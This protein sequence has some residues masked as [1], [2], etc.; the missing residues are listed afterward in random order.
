MPSKNKRTGKRFERWVVQFYAA[1]FN[2]IPFNNK[3][4]DDYQ[5]ATAGF[6]SRDEDAR[7][8]D[9]VFNNL[10]DDLSHLS[11]LK[12]QCKKIVTKGKDSIA[13]N[14]KPLDDMQIFEGDNKVLFTEVRRKSSKGREMLHNRYVTITPEYFKKLLIYEREVQR[15][16]SS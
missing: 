6:A 14:V 9:I 8:N 3:N 5:I 12:T 15:N 1:L 4:H 10:P 16:S 2:L 13:I 11:G 7:G